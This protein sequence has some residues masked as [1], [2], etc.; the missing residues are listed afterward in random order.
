MAERR[1]RLLVLGLNYAPE[2]IGI[3]P[4]TAGLA[5]GLAARGWDVDVVAGKPY[6]PA[7]RAMDCPDDGPAGGVNIVR[8]PHY[9]PARP[10]ALRRVLH[11]LSFAASAVPPM[12]ARAGDKP[13]LVLAVCPALLA[14]PTAWLAARRARAPLWLHVQDFEAEAATATGLVRQR[15]IAARVALAAERLLLRR[16]DVASSIGPAM[17]RKLNGK[18][19]PGTPTIELRNWA[20]HAAP[21]AEGRDYRREWGL[22]DRT[23]ALYSG[24]IANKQGLELVIDAARA[25]AARKDIAFVI[26]GEG[27]NRARLQA[28]AAGLDNIQFHDLQP[29][30]DV[31]ALMRMADIHLL[32]QLAEAAGLVLPSKLTNMLASGR[33]VV[34]TAAAGTNLAGEIDGCGIA[35]PPGNGALIAEAVV[36]LADAPEVARALGQAAQQRAAD[37]WDRDAILNRAD[38]R[39]RAWIAAQ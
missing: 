33:P 11:H 22:G 26:C 20:N 30:R 1:P 31:P 2:P 18:L 36:R 34:A 10:T 21:V 27:P 9:I 7:W 32:P 23:V 39:L 38:A 35:V 25:L 37:V 29:A 28:L 14:V 24:N 16:A 13:D 17:M 12:V 19:A 5:E 8:R 4:Y 3:G 15:S 6:Y